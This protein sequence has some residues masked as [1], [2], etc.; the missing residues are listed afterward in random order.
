MCIIPRY[1]RVANNII[2]E[3]VKALA[4]PD[5]LHVCSCCSRDPVQP[6]SV[7]ED[8]VCLISALILQLNALS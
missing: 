4:S 2:M 3:R 5:P 1:R 7:H 6:T 8:F